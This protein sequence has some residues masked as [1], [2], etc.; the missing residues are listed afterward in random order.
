MYSTALSTNE[1]KNVPNEAMG[2]YTDNKAAL[3]KKLN[4]C[5]DAFMDMF[6]PYFLFLLI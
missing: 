4:L 1:K 5:T 2:M 6:L 3:F